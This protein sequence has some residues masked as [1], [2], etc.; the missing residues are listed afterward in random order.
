MLQPL[1]DRGQ[2]ARAPM[3]VTDPVICRQC[4]CDYGHRHD[5]AVKDP[6]WN[7]DPPEADDRDLRRIDD[8]VYAHRTLVA[9]IRYR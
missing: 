9:E 3:A 4:R 6:G 5:L 8:G 7:P 1:G 2:E